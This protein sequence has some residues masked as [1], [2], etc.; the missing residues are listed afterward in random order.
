MGELF[1]K[2]LYHLDL[3]SGLVRCF[4]LRSPREWSRRQGRADLIS[5]DSSL[6]SGKKEDELET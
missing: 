6:L 1:D 3:H 2:Y 4:P 5:L